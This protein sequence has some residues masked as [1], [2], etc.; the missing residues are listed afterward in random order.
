[1]VCACCGCETVADCPDCVPPDELVNGDRCCPPGYPYPGSVGTD[2]C[3][4][5][6]EEDCVQSEAGYD[7]CDGECLPLPCPP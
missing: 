2:C 6:T 7:C 4:D 1:M 5:S 3:T